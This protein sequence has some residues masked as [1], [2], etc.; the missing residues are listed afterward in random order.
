MK[1]RMMTCACDA[2]RAGQGMWH[3][4]YKLFAAVKPPIVTFLPHGGGTAHSQN[5]PCRLHATGTNQYRNKQGTYANKIRLRKRPL[6]RQGTNAEQADHEAAKTTAHQQNH[7]SG[8]DVT[9]NRPHASRPTPN[10]PGMHG[11]K[12]DRRPAGWQ[13]HDAPLANYAEPLNDRATARNDLLGTPGPPGEHKLDRVRRHECAP[14]HASPVAHASSSRLTPTEKK[15]RW[16]C[17]QDRAYGLAPGPCA[18][19]SGG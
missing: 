2:A 10:L 6:Q 8:H 19:K 16:G 17:L 18:P 11:S 15:P 14:R 7:C 3:R 13:H 9:I 12:R 4:I 1:Y 5:V